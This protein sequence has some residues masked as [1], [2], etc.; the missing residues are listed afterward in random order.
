MNLFK[1]KSLWISLIVLIISLFF[2]GYYSAPVTVTTCIPPDMGGNC[3][4][5]FGTTPD[6]RASIGLLSLCMGV[7]PA[8]LVSLLISYLLNRRK[9]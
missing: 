3:T 9:K 4:N 2:Y 8:I 7:I 1:T 5:N 6:Y